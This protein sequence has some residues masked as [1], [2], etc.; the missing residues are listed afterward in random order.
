MDGAADNLGVRRGVAA[1]LRAD[2]PWL[3][4]MHRLNHRLELAAK[5]AFSKTYTDEITAM[6]TFIY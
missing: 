3:A 2:M 1:R 4:G 6:L 5:D